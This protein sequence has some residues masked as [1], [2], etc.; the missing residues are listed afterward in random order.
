MSIRTGLRVLAVGAA[1]VCA[2]AEARALTLHAGQSFTLAFHSLQDQGPDPSSNGPLSNGEFDLK[3]GANWL[4]TGEFITVTVIDDPSGDPHTEEYDLRPLGV[5]TG[6]EYIPPPIPS[7]GLG[8]GNLWADQEGSLLI[9]VLIGSVEIDTIT[10][11][12]LTEGKRY[13]SEYRPSAAAVPGPVAGAGLPALLAL[14]GFVW[15]RRRKAAAV[16]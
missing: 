14:G 13:S 12:V 2:T 10:I 15:A 1:M 5:G 11:T 6:S 3:F 16:T 7:V 9:T 4:D 8:M